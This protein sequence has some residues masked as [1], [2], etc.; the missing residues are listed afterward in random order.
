MRRETKHSV[1]EVVSPVADYRELKQPVS[2]H[3]SRP[4]NINGRTV[5]L[6][7]SEKTSSPPF[8]VWKKVS[9]TIIVPSRSAL[10]EPR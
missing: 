8:V 2:R 5:V 7:P 1:L 9:G 6:L 10:G 3:A 4:P